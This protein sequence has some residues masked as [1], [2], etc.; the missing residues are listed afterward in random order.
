M[1]KTLLIIIILIELAHLVLPALLGL[2]FTLIGLLLQFWWI[3]FLL[4]LVAYVLKKR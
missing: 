2:T 1:I 3:P 4:L